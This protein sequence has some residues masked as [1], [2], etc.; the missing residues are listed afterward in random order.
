MID[1]IELIYFENNFTKLY[2]CF[3]HHHYFELH[4]YI[5][6]GFMSSKENICGNDYAVYDRV[7]NFLLGKSFSF[8]MSCLWKAIYLHKC[9]C[10]R[11]DIKNKVMSF[12][13]NSMHKVLEYS[14]HISLWDGTRLT[15][16]FGLI[17]VNLIWQHLNW[18]FL[19][20]LSAPHFLI[21]A[22]EYEMDQRTIVE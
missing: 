12:T 15:Y 18:I 5:L 21:D 19:L 20:Y 16:S 17:R 13:H 4:A 7:W 1:I 8:I 2:F 22:R 14:K 6:R 3:D 11:L 10:K 9:A